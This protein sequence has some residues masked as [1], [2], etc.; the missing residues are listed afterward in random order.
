MT[1][2]IPEYLARGRVIEALIN[3]FNDKIGSWN[4][5]CPSHVSL[6]ARNDGKELAISSSQWDE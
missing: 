1:P 2:G 4:S 5:I 6:R 3:V